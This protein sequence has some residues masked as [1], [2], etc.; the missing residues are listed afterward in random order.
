MMQSV[1]INLAMLDNLN[2]LELF[3]TI[4][5]NLGCIKWS[6]TPKKVYS[7]LSQNWQVGSLT[8]QRM[9]SSFL[10]EVMSVTHCLFS[11]LTTRM[12]MCFSTIS[13]VLLNTAYDRLMFKPFALQS[14]RI[15][16]Y[17]WSIIFD[18]QILLINFFWSIALI[19]NYFC[20][21]VT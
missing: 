7:Y 13:P 3:E 5:D 18:N 19:I 14:H 11:T 12:Q 10:L 4:W 9:L 2:Y 20:I 6:W 21:V 17:F 16:H 8:F 15:I 1:P